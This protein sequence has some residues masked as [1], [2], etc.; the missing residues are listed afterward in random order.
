MKIRVNSVE[1]RNWHEIGLLPQHANPQNSTGS[2]EAR[3]VE[4]TEA[5]T[6][7]AR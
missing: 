2:I 4:V 1:H 6:A 7:V 3:P 5:L